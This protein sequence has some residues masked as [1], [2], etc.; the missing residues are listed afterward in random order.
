M[1]D[2]NLD[3]LI[4]KS[5]DKALQYTHA[6]FVTAVTNKEIIFNVVTD[7][8]YKILKG[9]Q[10]VIFF[11]NAFLYTIAPLIFIPI[12]AY[13]YDNLYLLFG[14]LISYLGSFLAGSRMSKLVFF[15]SIFCIIFWAVNGFNF[16]NI[17]TL[18]FFCLW[19]GYFFFSMASGIEDEYAKIAVLMNE[20]VFNQLSI[21]RKILIL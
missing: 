21:N 15:Y 19:F 9:S 18:S 14:V 11:I 5:F 3:D 13:H 17:V 6:E 10:K 2:Q 4:N 8:K 12:I 1:E 7:N 20:E 16:N